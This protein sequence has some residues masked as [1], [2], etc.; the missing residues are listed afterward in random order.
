MCCVDLVFLHIFLSMLGFRI[1]LCLKISVA[2]LLT[3]NIF[4]F[5]FR[6]NNHIQEI[7]LP[8]LDSVRA[9]YYPDSETLFLTSSTLSPLSTTK[10]SRSQVNTGR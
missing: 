5:C 4:L 8:T 3:Q 7:C 10:S 9:Y 2:F 6:L 1:L